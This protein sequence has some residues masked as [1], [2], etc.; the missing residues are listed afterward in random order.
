L[1]TPEMG[2]EEAEV[3]E[4]DFPVPDVYSRSAEFG[5][6]EETG[7]AEDDGTTEGGTGRK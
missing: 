2:V 6:L 3:D 4:E 7:E 5:T 1:P